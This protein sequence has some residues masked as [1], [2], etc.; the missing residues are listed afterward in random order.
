MYASILKINGT[1]V[2]P[3]DGVKYISPMS[4]DDQN[5][6]SENLKIDGAQFLSRI[7]L[8]NG[9]SQLA[10]E[11]V[12]DMK[13]S[14][15]LVNLGNDRFVPAS[16]ILLAKSFTKDQAQALEG[17]GYTLGSTF[18]SSVETSAGIVLSSAHPAQVMDRRAK[19][20]EFVGRGSVDQGP[21]APAIA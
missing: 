12:E 11:S 15:G 8:A 7:S 3:L 21:K 20:L 14:I 2:I 16:N 17:K 19:A 6:L 9:T 5:K 10:R 13:S 4:E 1:T 18:R